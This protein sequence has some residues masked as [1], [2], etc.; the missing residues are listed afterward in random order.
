V[1][2]TQ[3]RP[4]RRDNSAGLAD[5]V[6]PETIPP[7]LPGLPARAADRGGDRLARLRA[8]Y[9]AFAAAGIRFADEPLASTGH[10][11]QVRPPDQVLAVPRHGNCLDLSL[12]FAGACLSAGLHPLLAVCQPADGGTAHAVVVV[13]TGGD[14]P[15]PGGDGRYDPPGPSGELVLTSAP[16]WPGG[17]RQQADGP[18][19]F[20]PVDISRAASGYSHGLA[21]FGEQAA[22]RLR[23]RPSP[24]RPANPGGNG[25]SAWT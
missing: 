19:M 4:W 9:D 22:S 7:L 12:V 10:A 23:L 3:W 13:W 14:W 11:Q 15:G 24:D 2:G 17:L 6:S 20:V 25:S 21:G 16:A 8:V 1:S 18:G 5:Y